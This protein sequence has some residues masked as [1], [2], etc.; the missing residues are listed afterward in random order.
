M[1]GIDALTGKPLDGFDHVLQSIQ[2]I[3]ITALGER[4]KREWFGNPGNRL[5]GEN[6]TDRTILLWFTVSWMLLEIFEPRFRVVGFRVADISRAGGADFIMDGEYRPYAHLDFEQASVY[7][8]VDPTGVT[9]RS[10]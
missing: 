9:V 4:V 3:F 5:L 7:I 10:A 2:T 1:T 6:A 8:A